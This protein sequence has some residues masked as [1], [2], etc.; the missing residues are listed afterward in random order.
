M[1]P[2]TFQLM[3]VSGASSFLIQHLKIS[4]STT[5]FPLRTV[6]SSWR[7]NSSS[8]VSVLQ[9]TSVP[10]S[11]VLV[12]L[13]RRRFFVL[14]RSIISW[15]GNIYVLGLDVII[16]CAQIDEQLTNNR[17]AEGRGGLGATCSTKE[18]AINRRKRAVWIIAVRS[19]KGRRDQPGGSAVS[20]KPHI[21]KREGIVCP[22][23]GLAAQPPGIEPRA[24]CSLL[25]T[26]G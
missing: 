17:E 20:P 8:A 19:Q 5:S 1:R 18:A 24:A 15:L 14:V 22:R 6:K 21:P 3:L 7:L 23:A 26:R 9:S 10:L 2:P 11:L 13:L 25:R 16:I 12:S 4:P